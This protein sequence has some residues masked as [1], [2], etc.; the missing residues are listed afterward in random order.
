MYFGFEGNNFFI[1]EGVG[2]GN[3]WDQ[4]DFGVEVFYD[5]DIQG[6]EGVVSGLDEEDVGVDVVVN[7]VYVVD[8]VF[9]I[10]VGVEVLF[11]VVDNWFLGFIVVDKVIKVRCVD[12]CKFEMNICF[13][14]ICVDRLNIDGFGNNF[15]VGFFVF[16]GWV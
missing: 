15:E 6:F 16:F 8:F 5:F 9:S 12:D 1:G 4:V 11:D 14:N 2:F 10:E 13:F 7:N 3:D